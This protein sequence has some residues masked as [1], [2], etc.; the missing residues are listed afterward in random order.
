MDLIISVLEFTYLLLVI[1]I[2]S[3]VESLNADRTNICYTTME[4]EG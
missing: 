4:A 3:W 1:C 2:N